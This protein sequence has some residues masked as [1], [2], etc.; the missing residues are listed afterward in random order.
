MTLS[1][2]P[3]GSPLQLS[4]PGDPVLSAKRIPFA[5]AIGIFPSAPS[6]QGSECPTFCEKTRQMLFVTP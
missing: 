4:I 2:L 5:H 6:S 1:G 3:V